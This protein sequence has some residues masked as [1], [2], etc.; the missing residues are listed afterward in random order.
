MLENCPA[1]LPD[2]DIHKFVLDQ[3]GPKTPPVSSPQTPPPPP[4]R[5]PQ[6]PELPGSSPPPLPPVP[7][8][9]IPPAIAPL[10]PAL[11]RPS[12]L[13][14][15]GTRLTR[16]VLPFPDCA[17]ATSLRAATDRIRKAQAGPAKTLAGK[18]KRRG[19]LNPDPR[20]P[21]WHCSACGVTA[22][23][24]LQHA[25]HLRSRRHTRLA[26]PTQYRC[27]VCNLVL[28]SRAD[29]TRH[30]GGRQHRTRTR[31]PTTKNGFPLASFFLLS[32]LGLPCI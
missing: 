23:G 19:Y 22:T 10:G 16:T 1:A 15:R 29:H 24:R 8:L 25:E 18:F 32:T 12:A 17:A 11:P 13:E 3:P 26:N 7:R 30:L 14:A 2:V 21:R 31:G 27:N 4:G 9:P 6:T 20:S 28:Y 5:E